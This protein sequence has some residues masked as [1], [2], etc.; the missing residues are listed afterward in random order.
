MDIINKYCVELYRVF[1]DIL[2][3]NE[4]GKIF[5]MEIVET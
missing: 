2:K 3:N 5:L 4:D 1:V